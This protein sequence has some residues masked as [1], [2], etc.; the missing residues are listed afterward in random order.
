MYGITRNDFTFVEDPDEADIGILTMT[1]NYYIKTGKKELALKFIQ[2]IPL[3]GKKIFI[4]NAGDFGLRMPFFSNA[5]VFRSG[6]YK[7]RF[8]K[9]ER[10]IPP[11]IEDPLNLFGK[12]VISIQIYKNEPVVGFCGWTNK[13]LLNAVKEKSRV[14]WRNCRYYAGLKEEEPQ[15]IIS[16]T[17]LRALILKKLE[18]SPSVK[19]NFIKRKKYRAGVREGKRNH[20]T[21]YEYLR[22]IEDSDYILCVRGSGN[23]SVRFYETLAMGRIPVYINTNSKLP[24]EKKNYWKE[25]VVWVEQN[26]L[27]LI[28]E[29]IHAFH[30]NLDPS[31]FINLQK[32]NRKLWE[33]RLRIK[34]FFKNSFN[35]ELSQR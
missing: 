16:S 22:N 33:N 32:K 7:S 28:G 35:E 15:E 26:E 8:R 9:N 13:S 34:G 3:A 1:W 2:S 23:F 18:E 21:T 29:K 20:D 10:I 11:F 17:Y 4:Y 25:H 14:M 12:Q 27:H 24:L 31:S 6:G 19:T 30:L 5:V